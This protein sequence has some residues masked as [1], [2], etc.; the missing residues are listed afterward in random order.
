MF[1]ATELREMFERGMTERRTLWL[2]VCEWPREHY[3][4]GVPLPTPPA[5]RSLYDELAESVTEAASWEPDWP[6]R[7]NAERTTST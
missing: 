2:T 1:G 3:V 7:P 6:L 4:L 5:E